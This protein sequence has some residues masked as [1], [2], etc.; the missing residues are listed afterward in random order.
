MW[1]WGKGKYGEIDKKILDFDSFNFLRG[2][3]LCNGNSTQKKSGFLGD[4]SKLTKTPYK[5]AEGAYSY[6]NPERPLSQYSR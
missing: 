6:F 5:D 3:G 2:L 1:F 4:Y